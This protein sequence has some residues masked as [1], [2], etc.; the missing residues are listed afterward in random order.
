MT[1]MR[2]LILAGE[3]PPQPGGVADYTRQIALE[4][5]RQG[6]AVRVAAPPLAESGHELRD[7]G[8]EIIRLPW[9]Y[10][11]RGL[12]RLPRLWRASSSRWTPDCTLVQYTPYAFGWRALNLPLIWRLSRSPPPGLAVMFHEIGYPFLPGQSRKH[13]A[14]ARAHRYMAARLARAARRIW[15]STPAWNRLLAEIAPQAVAAE[16]LPVPSSLPVHADPRRIAA[17]RREL[18]PA[19][20]LLLGHFG[21]YG[22]PVGGLLAAI[23]PALLAARPADRLCLFGRHSREFAARFAL[24]ASLAGRI[25]ALGAMDV[26]ELAHHLSACD[27]LLQPYPDGVTTRRTSLM[28]G[29]AL[30]LPILTTRGPLTESLWEE[31]RALALIPVEARQQWAAAVEALGY[32]GARRALG[33][34]ARQLYNEEFSVAAVVAKMRAGSP[35]AAAKNLKTAP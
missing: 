14:L 4:L 34:R 3:Y 22:A 32:A 13:D 28:A 21:T 2:W 6:D 19:E 30:G 27:L 25:V 29:L 10:G 17:I 9:G 35:L 33:E 15:V 11:W 26:A 18:A 7:A 5:A 1:S 16:W 12:A 23:L 8:V 20:G 24:P 31:R